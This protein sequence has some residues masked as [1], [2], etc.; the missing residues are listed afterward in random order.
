VPNTPRVTVHLVPHTHWD[1][2]WYEPFQRFR[3][4]LVDLLDDVLARAEADPRF[5]FTL[6]GQLAAVDDHLEV[7]PEDTERVAALV[8]RGQLAIG[9]WLILADEFCCSGENLVRNLELGTARADKLGGAMPV[10]YLPDMFG[11]CAQM[12]QLLHRAGIGHACLWRGVPDEVTRHAF[13]WHAPDGSA[14]R[15][16]YLPGGYGNAAYLLADAEKVA[17]RTAEFVDRMRPWFGEDPVLAMYGTDH[18]APLP[19]LVERVA[20]LDEADGPYRLQIC[21]LAD[22][23]ASFDPADLDGLPRWQGELRSH[24]RA[25]I[26]PGIFSVRGHLKRAMADAERMVERYAEPW[27]A[28]WS[29]TW[30]ARFLDMAWH[31]LVASSCHDSVTGCG[32]DETA[33]QVAARLAEAEQLGQAVRDR[34]V[35]ELAAAVPG[36]AVL[37]LNPSPADRVGLVRFD[38]V[39]PEDAAEV[40][41]RLADGTTLPTQE[42]ARPSRELFTGSFAAES[43]REALIRRSF[44]QE[45]FNRRIQRWEHDGSTVT[46]HVGRVGD[47]TFDIDTA[48]DEIDALATAAGGTWTLRIL[49]EPSRTLLA[50]VSVPALGWTTGRAVAGT[51]RRARTV[52]VG[53]STLD[54]GGVLVS[55]NADGTLRIAGPDGTVLDGVGR[56][57]DGGDAGD[58][59]NY[60]PPATDTLVDEPLSVQIEPAEEG[61]LLGALL[62]TRA[63][64]WHAGLAADRAAR[65]AETVLTVVTTRV[66][67]RV[68]EPFVRL[69]VDFDNR[70]VDHRVRLHVPLPAPA[71]HSSA[72]G[73]FAVVRRGLTSEGGYGEEPVP[74]FPAYSFVD[75]RNAAVLLPA[76]TEYELVDGGRELALTL[77]R[78]TGQISRSVHP[79]RE[80]PAGP[81]IPTPQAQSP[82]AQS[83][84]LAVLP[85]AGGWAGA[86]VV[87]AA[88]RYRH[89][90]LAVPGRAGPGGALTSA[91]GLSVAGRGVTMTSLRRREDWLELRL[92]AYSDAP[93]VATVGPLTEARRA[94]LLGRPADTIPLTD[95]H[96]TLPLAPWEIATIQLRR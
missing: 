71:S 68:G 53:Q 57:V 37:V 47:P 84:R 17:E 30:P 81:E 75:A 78:A 59:Y 12:P 16:E 74:T 48:A 92:V 86:G 19:T 50:H 89:D 7:R 4:R 46:F 5:C 82:G 61:P 64:R 83:V 54:N 15:C 85:H 62:V 22:Y 10:G 66:E 34:T 2:E 43:L 69:S 45:M 56:I 31:R 52:Y 27:A 77:L 8:E 51:G 26:L 6:D 42:L 24:A 21:T 39:A 58:S 72:E 67:L 70:G 1:R 96:L 40:V 36:D 49:A 87:G 55:V 20:A 29:A 28:L 32:V 18:S 44:G 33:V 76:M 65:S 79:Y 38:A 11:H 23:L 95:D 60:A 41:L 63:Y 91:S 94:D 9:P 25:N 88:E 14:V 90:L 93:T 35:A 80:E 3:L 13:A 73:Q